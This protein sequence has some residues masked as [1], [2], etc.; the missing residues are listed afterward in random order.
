[1]PE[2]D[3]ARWCCCLISRPALEHFDT[4]ISLHVK[5][6]QA[7]QLDFQ[8]HGPSLEPLAGSDELGGVP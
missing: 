3:D 1:M 4:S 5:T 7:L 2:L 8:H 6:E